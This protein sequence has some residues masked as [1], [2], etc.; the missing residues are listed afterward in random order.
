S[1]CNCQSHIPPESLT[2]FCS[3]LFIMSLALR[4]YEPASS[5]IAISKLA[6]L[7]SITRSIHCGQAPRAEQPRF[8]ELLRQRPLPVADRGVLPLVHP[9]RHQLQ[10]GDHVLEF[11]RS[12]NRALRLQIEPC[13]RRMALGW[14]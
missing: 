12:A 11:G 4:Q 2:P 8:A 7:F 3:K 1:L 14:P 5:H 9:Q 6:D 10:V 13:S